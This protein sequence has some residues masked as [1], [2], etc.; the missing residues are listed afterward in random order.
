MA[1]PDRLAILEFYVIKVAEDLLARTI[2]RKRK[3]QEIPDIIRQ[4]AATVSAEIFKDLATVGIKF[5]I[6]L[7]GPLEGIAKQV[8]RNHAGDQFGSIFDGV[9]GAGKQA[10]VDFLSGLGK[11]R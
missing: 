8:M 4:E 6:A 1:P 2:I 10:A 3:G 9:I 11:K 5:G 7:T